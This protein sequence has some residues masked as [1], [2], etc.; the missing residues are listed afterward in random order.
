MKILYAIQG[1]GNGHISRAMEIIPLLQKRCETDI[2]VSGCQADLEL[3]FA[4]KYRLHG[5]GFVFGKSGGIDFQKTYRKANTRKLLKE[6]KEL[7]VTEYDFILNDFEPVSAWAS[8]RNKVPCIALSH[9][10]SLLDKNTPRPGHRDPLGSF[11]LKNYAPASYHFG[12]H[13]SRFSNT[14]F[15]PVIRKPIR[16][17]AKD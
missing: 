14:I 17:C 11:I 4:V 2:L 15:T 6:I 16:E 12:L 10:A 3:P 7:P 5:L 9:Q 8:Y 13:F 1:T